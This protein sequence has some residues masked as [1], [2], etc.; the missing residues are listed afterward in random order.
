MKTVV[1]KVVCALV[2]GVVL[3][4]GSLPALALDK[5]DVNTATMEQLLEVKGVGEVLAQRIIEYRQVHK[6]FK[7]LD[8]LNNVKGVGG[9]KLEKMLPYLTLS[10]K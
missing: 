2:L 9:K 7:T 6:S 4:V 3:S 8:E 5:I 10:K 1:R